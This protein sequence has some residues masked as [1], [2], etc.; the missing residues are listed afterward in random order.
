MTMG[1]QLQRMGMGALSERQAEQHLNL[2]G[3]QLGLIPSIATSHG[4][5]ICYARNLCMK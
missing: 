2:L 4:P 3:Y 1:P 5:C